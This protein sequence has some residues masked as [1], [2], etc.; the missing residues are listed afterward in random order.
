MKIRSVRHNN[1]KK[2]FEVGTSTKKLVLPFSKAA[3]DTHDRR[4]GHG[5]LRRRGG[6]PRGVYLRPPLRPH[7]HGARRASA[8]VQPGS[9]L[10]PR[11]PVVPI[12]ARSAEASRRKPALEARDRAPARDVRGAVVS[13][14][15]IRRTTASLSISCLRCC[16]CSTVTLTWSFGRRPPDATRLRT[17]S[18]NDASTV[19]LL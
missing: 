5:A 17:C 3:T 16:R 12:D 13:L 6:R 10:P 7:R 18:F 14:C 8:R 9:D 4:P 2:V 19:T 11:S 15:S 1:R